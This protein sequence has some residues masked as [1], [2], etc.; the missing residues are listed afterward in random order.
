[1]KKMLFAAALVLVIQAPALAFMPFNWTG[2]KATRDVNAQFFS[3]GQGVPGDGVMGGGDT[4]EFANQFT[5]D[6]PIYFDQIKQDYSSY[7]P[8]GATVVP[9]NF[10]Y[11]LYTG[12][13]F[14][15]YDPTT[16]LP[17]GSRI[18]IGQGQ[19]SRTKTGQEE[20]T[21]AVS[22]VNATYLETGTYWLS[23]EYQSHADSAAYFN[24]EYGDSGQANPVPEPSTMAM[25]LFGLA[26]LG[27][28]RL[29]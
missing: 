24:V 29:F 25:M 3:A 26:G 20:I 21:A 9:I 11:V 18:V 22:V 4:A 8:L 7:L 2:E 23:Y 6:T 10:N 5:V 28:R 1:M 15:A 12:D 16:A 19:V 17:G 27:A 14:K 13:Y